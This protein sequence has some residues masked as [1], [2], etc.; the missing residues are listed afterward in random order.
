MRDYN[1]CR[2][3]VD[4]LVSEHRRLHSLL[5]QTRAAIIGSGGGDRDVPREEIARVLQRLHDE[6]ARHFTEEEEGG[7]M[8]EAV[9]RCP[10]LAGDM[11]QIEEEHKEL[12]AKVKAMIAQAC[13]ASDTVEARLAL[14]TEFDDFDRRIH[15]HEAAENEILRQDFG[16]NINGEDNQPV[17]LILD[18]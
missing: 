18:V 6:L 1:E 5:R 10:R 16:A 12:L 8:D 9:S 17:P 11:L 3:Y 15:A 7:C 14:E 13:S 4:H 2:P